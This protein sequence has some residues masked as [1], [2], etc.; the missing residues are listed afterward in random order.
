MNFKNTFYFH[1]G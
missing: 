1:S